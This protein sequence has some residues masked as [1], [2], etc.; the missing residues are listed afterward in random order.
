MKISSGSNLV[1]VEDFG[2]MRI[3]NT[4]RYPTAE[5]ERLVRFAAKGIGKSRVEIHVKNSRRVFAGRAWHIIGNNRIVN[6][7]KYVDDLVVVRIGPPAKFP[8]EFSYPRLKTVPR[9]T[10]RDWKEAIVSVT[11]HELYHIKQRRACRRASEVKAERWALKR[12]EAY[13]KQPNQ[14]S[15]NSTVRKSLFLSD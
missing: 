6:V 9:Y 10:I 5:V 1:Q 8:I 3:K 2:K 13:R 12:L 11:A 15:G 7:A 4:S 14:D